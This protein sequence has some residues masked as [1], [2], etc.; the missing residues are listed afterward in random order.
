[1][2]GNQNNAHS[3]V[4]PSLKDI[5]LSTLTNGR[6]YHPSPVAWEDEVLYFLF[7][8]RFSD[9]LEYGGFGTL[10]GSPV[11]GPTAKRKTPLFD[12]NM[13]AGKADR[14][15]WFNSGKTWCGGT[16]AG[17]KDKLGYLQRLGVTSAYNYIKS[18]ATRSGAVV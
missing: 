7:V 4:E 12:I 13:D 18:C 11:T 1:M 5:D 9:N 15:T 14:Q 17:I 6:F 16:L 8:D 3:V 2:P 10:D